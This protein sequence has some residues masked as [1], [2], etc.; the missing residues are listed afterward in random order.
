MPSFAETFSLLSC[1]SLQ[2]G[3]WN[4]I[5]WATLLAK[6]NWAVA[7]FPHRN[8]V[9][10]LRKT[11]EHEF[12]KFAKEPQS[13]R[14]SW[15]EASG[16]IPWTQSAKQYLSQEDKSWGSRLS[17]GM[18]QQATVLMAVLNRVV[19]NGPLGAPTACCRSFVFTIPPNQNLLSSFASV[20]SLFLNLS[21]LFL[22]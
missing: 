15:D 12:C 22:H 11:P 4:V 21:V 5:G 19:L 17:S 20:V 14:G 13:D 7:S 3:P 16:A 2:S 8:V 1:F 6:H 9:W 18:Q 10:R